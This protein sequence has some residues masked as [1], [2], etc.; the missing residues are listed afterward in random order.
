MEVYVYKLQASALKHCNS[1][2]HRY[3]ANDKRCTAT[4]HPYH[5]HAFVFPHRSPCVH[6]P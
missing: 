1:Y 4:T 3:S 5:K 6:A 2:Y